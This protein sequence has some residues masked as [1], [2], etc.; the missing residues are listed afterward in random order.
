MFIRLQYFKYNVFHVPNL[1]K[2]AKEFQTIRCVIEKAL[3]ANV[4]GFVQLGN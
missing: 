2:I 1:R 4:R 3:A